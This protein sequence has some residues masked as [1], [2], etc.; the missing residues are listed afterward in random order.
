VRLSP[1]AWERWQQRCS[2]LDLQSEMS[3]LRRAGKRIINTLRSSWERSQGVGTWPAHQDYLLSP[4]GAVF[5]VCSGTVIT[6]LTVREIKYWE[7][8]RIQAD[9]QRRRHSFG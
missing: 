7:R 4:G 3:R 5:I 1:H 6:V 2:H 9:R 8:R